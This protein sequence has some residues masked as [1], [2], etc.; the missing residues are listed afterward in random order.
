MQEFINLLKKPEAAI[1]VEGKKDQQALKEFDIPSIQLN[2][3]PIYK[4]VESIEQKEVIILTDLDKAGR[5]LYSKLKHNLQKKGK[6]INDKPREFLFK[7][8]RIT[9]IESL[10]R[11]N[12]K[13]N[14]F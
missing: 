13:T 3:Q 5:K 1:I 7:N 12:L 2:N 6:R 14:N 10:K 9:Y 4:V 8:T 11:L